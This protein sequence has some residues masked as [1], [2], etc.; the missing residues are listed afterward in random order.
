MLMLS[1]LFSWIAAVEH[2]TWIK[3]CGVNIL[4]GQ[5][6]FLLSQRSPV[7]HAGCALCLAS[8][9]VVDFCVH[10]S[11]LAEG[12][13]PR[14]HVQDAGDEV[15]LGEAAERQRLLAVVIQVSAVR[16]VQPH[17]RR[18]AVV[19]VVHGPT[20]NPNTGSFVAAVLLN[21]VKLRRSKK[22]FNSNKQ[23]VHYFI[24]PSMVTVFTFHW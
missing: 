18:G 7:R 5:L 3:F 13:G 11:V 8:A 19:K 2:H 4:K 24:F 9:C 15:S 6:W 20:R 21:D 16:S 12:D 23:N 1:H 14:L 22:Y 10:L 17:V